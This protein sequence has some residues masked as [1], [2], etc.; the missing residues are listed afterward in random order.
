MNTGAGRAAP[1]DAV[2]LPVLWVTTL[3]CPACRTSGALYL[4]DGVGT[5]CRECGDATRI[6]PNASNGTEDP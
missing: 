1:S 2:G 3:T 5:V 6:T 4:F